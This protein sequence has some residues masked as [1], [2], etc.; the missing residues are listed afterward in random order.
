MGRITIQ[1]RGEI[2]ADYRYTHNL[3]LTARNC[4]VAKNTARLWL[5]RSS[6]TGDV[7]RKK[8][9]GRKP[10]MSA[11]A[12]ARAVELLTAEVG[13]TSASVAQALHQEGLVD[14]PPHRTTVARAAKRDA[15]QHGQPIRCV[16][17]RPAKRLTAANKLK[18]LAF[19]QANKKR[20][21]SSCLFTD[22][23]RFLFSY[24]GVQVGRSQWVKKGEGRSAVR[25]NH[26]QAVNLYL[27]LTKLGC[28]PC[29]VVAGTSKNKSPFINK[30]GKPAKNITSQEYISVLNS[31]FLPEGS[32]LFSAI[33]V[34]K[35]YFQQDNDPAHNVAAGVVAEYSRQNTADVEMVADWPPNSP[36]LNPI[37][38][39]W[40]I[41]EAEVSAK[42]CDTFEEFQAAVVHACSN[43][44]KS[45]LAKLV[46][47]MP[48][49]IEQVLEKEG[50]MTSY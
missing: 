48:K 3:A 20:T 15:R 1:K 5:Q 41:S 8:G 43:V 23:K 22:R 42:K 36:D 44:P 25:V 35:W 38:N 11:G 30:Q 26:P 46:N 14:K 29:T 32:R 39:L 10:A 33:G 19:A 49:R 40:G 2:V 37:E 50:D 13:S 9:S 17:G 6:S 21:W 4:G 28:T 18:R 47:S 12:A 16:V 34:N 7:L 24:P 45:K 31:N 27:G